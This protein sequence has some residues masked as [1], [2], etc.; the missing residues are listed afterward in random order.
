M[1]TKLAYFFIMIG[2]IGIVLHLFYRLNTEK[3]IL[4]FKLQANH[5]SLVAGLKVNWQNYLL[6]NI[7]DGKLNHQYKLRWNRTGDKLKD[8]FFPMKT[9]IHNWEEYQKFVK[10]DNE[11]SIK[12]FL[13]TALNRKFS[14]D[15]ILAIGEWKTRY[16]QLPNVETEYEKTLYDI[17]AQR[18]YQLIFEQFAGKKDYTFLSGEIILDKVYISVSQEGNIEAFVPSARE[19]RKKLLP[20]FLSKHR[21]NSAT[22]GTMPWQLNFPLTV[23]SNKQLSFWEYFVPVISFF[24]LFSGL[25]LY[26]YSYFD[27]KKILT[28]RVSFLNQVV[29]EL[30]TPLT[31]L[32]LH[33]QLILKGS[34]TKENLSAFNLS[35]DKL[36]A[37]FDDIVLMNRPFEKIVLEL[38]PKEVAN[39]LLQDFV[40]DN[41]QLRIISAFQHDFYTDKK[42]LRIILRNLISNAIRYGGDA[43]LTVD[44]NQ[45]QTNILI[46]DSGNGISINESLNIFKEFYRSDNAKKKNTAGL[47]L[48]LYLVKKISQEMGAEIVLTN[49]GQPGAEFRLTL[50]GSVG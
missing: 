50:S 34:G 30:K 45:S 18:S 39:I 44:Y 8:I 2:T 42:R 38:M 37:L 47:G 48:G 16:R 32:K 28:K 25:I 4:E 41:P 3:K 12:K 13:H 43:T 11:I 29:H 46:K 21:I 19:I 15:R 17:E 14:W 35:L 27:Q 36:N 1:K 24:C 9:T 31:G 20:L 26:L 5:T 10:L 7:R 40:R 22:L 23:A 33:S 49:A 6:N